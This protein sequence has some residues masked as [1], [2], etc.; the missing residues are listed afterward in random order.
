MNDSKETIDWDAYARDYDA[1]NALAPY[2]DMQNAVFDE[3]RICG[4]KTILDAACGTGNLIQML[5]QHFN[6]NNFSDFFILGLDRSRA[7]LARAEKKSFKGNI[8]LICADL[9]HCLPFPDETFETIVCINALYALRDPRG[10]LSGFHKTLTRDGR[11]IL[12]TPKAGYENGLMLKAHSKSTKPDAYWHNAHASPERE[13][14]LIK[15]AIDDPEVQ[16]QMLRIAA[17]NRRIRTERTFHFYQPEEFNALLMQ[18]GFRVIVMQHTYADQNIL[19]VAS[20]N[21]DIK[22]EP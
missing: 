15:E 1:L 19:V 9:D 11:L 18:T 8:R 6:E 12:V 17:W 4:G 13:Q 5:A 20:K 14:L 3:V 10:T 7:M 2:R 16:G 21:R 22:G